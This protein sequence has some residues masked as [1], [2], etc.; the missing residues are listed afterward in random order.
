MKQTL[1]RVSMGALIAI[2]FSLFAGHL[3]GRL[4]LRSNFENFVKSSL[5]ATAHEQSTLDLSAYARLLYS[6]VQSSERYTTAEVLFCRE[7]DSIAFAPGSAKADMKGP[8]CRAAPGKAAVSDWISAADF[9]FVSTIPRWDESVQLVARVSP[10][11]LNPY[12]LLAALLS[13]F[14][15]TAAGVMRARAR[16]LLKLAR[17]DVALGKI[18]AQVAHDIRSPL[19]AL[20]AAEP[21]LKSLPEESRILVRSAVGRIRDIANGLLETKRQESAK[22][23]PQLLSSLIDALISEKR[24]QYRARLGIEIGARIAPDAYGLF[25]RVDPVGFKRVLSNLVNNGVEAIEGTGCVRLELASRNGNACVTV[26][27]DGKGIPREVLAKLEVGSVTHGKA[28]GSGIGLHHARAAVEAWGGT[29][30]I[31]SQESGGAVVALSIPLTNAPAWFVPR[32]ELTAGTSIAILDDDISIHQIWLGRFESAGARSHGIKFQHFSTAAEFAA[33][34]AS[35]SRRASFENTFFLVDYELLGEGR[36]GLDLIES[37]GIAENSFLVTSR[38]EEPELRARCE[39]LGVRMIPKAMAAFVPIR[40]T[41]AA[42]SPVAA[43]KY[44]A[45]LID[46]EELV[47][48]TWRITADRAGKRVLSCRTLEEFLDR[49]GDLNRSTPV[50]VDVSLGRGAR[51]EEVSKRVAEAGF[52]DVY[53]AT[54][55]RAEEFSRL[56]WL[57][58]VVG[59]EPPW[60]TELH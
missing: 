36:S 58:G 10:R 22:P 37:L 56:S 12:S 39:R 26:S 33:E 20:E 16:M 42:G 13:L 29:L 45:V 5:A 21:Q 50:Y 28:G 11:V 6:L 32:M 52:T 54:G 47:H 30:R 41:P 7:G 31:A 27:D 4:I 57:K 14:V 44:D 35:A 8:K 43:E 3:A 19:A 17:A 2:G 25:A 1:S 34:L 23:S 51:G 40:I 15:C 59:K 18:A 46:D 48:S 24:L 9:E 38:F 60:M 49:A 55:H 53:L